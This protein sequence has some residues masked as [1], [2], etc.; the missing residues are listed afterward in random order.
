MPGDA[1]VPLLSAA[2][3]AQDSFSAGRR[4]RRPVASRSS[5]VHGL[6]TPAII[7]RRMAHITV[8]E[9][10]VERLEGVYDRVDLHARREGFAAAPK[11][12]QLV[13][14]ARRTGNISRFGQPDA[15]QIEG[16]I[17]ELS[18]SLHPEALLHLRV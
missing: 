14:L 3:A 17:E 15:A 13:N 8:H 4:Y 10:I 1:T 2:S 18:D 5:T 11:K 16:A 9:R 6:P 7:Q 12:H